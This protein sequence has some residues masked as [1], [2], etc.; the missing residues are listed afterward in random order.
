MQKKPKRLCF[1]AYFNSHSAVCQGLSTIK[2]YSIKAKNRIRERLF[3]LIVNYAETIHEQ[4]VNFI[5][6]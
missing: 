2:Q 1:I 4:I 3:Q 6:F 5:T